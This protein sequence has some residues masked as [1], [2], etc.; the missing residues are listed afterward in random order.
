MTTTTNTTAREQREAKVREAHA[1]LAQGVQNLRTREDWINWLTFSAQ[2]SKHHRYSFNNMMLIWF[3]N[4]NA[5]H[6]ASYT[7]WQKDK[8]QVRKGERGLAIFAPI[9]VKTTEEE[10]QKNP[11]LGFTRLVG[12]KVVNT[13]DISQTDGPPIPQQ[14]NGGKESDGEAPEGLWEKLV[15]VAHDAGYRVELTDIPET[16]GGLINYVHKVI[17]IQQG[18]G[19]ARTVKSLLHELAHMMLHGPSVDSEGNAVPARVCR[20]DAEVEA[21]SAAYILAQYFEITPDCEWSFAYVAGWSARDG[22]A[23]TRSG[24]RIMRVVKRILAIADP[25]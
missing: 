13:F 19:P 20:N 24:E 9:I 14:P 15:E 25:E 5:R 18:L 23:V 22:D 11:A 7:Q 12:F 17:K 16:D 21:E 10:R 2:M 8:R 4:P 6:C 1:M 3:Q